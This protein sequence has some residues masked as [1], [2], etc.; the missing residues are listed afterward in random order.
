MQGSSEVL[1]DAIDTIIAILLGFVASLLLV[2]AQVSGSCFVGCVWIYTKEELDK[3]SAKKKLTAASHIF[4]WIILAVGLTMLTTGTTKMQSTPDQF[5]FFGGLVC[6][7]HGLFI[8]AYVV[9]AIVVA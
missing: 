2:L 7:I 5:L 6:F 4:S 3:A 8:V 1:G 9:S